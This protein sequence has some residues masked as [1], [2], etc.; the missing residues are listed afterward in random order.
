[1][2]NTM[3]LPRHIANTIANKYQHVTNM[4]LTKHGG[5][6]TNK[7]VKCTGDACEHRTHYLCLIYMST[8]GS[9]CT[10]DLLDAKNALESYPA[11]AGQHVVRRW[12]ATGEYPSVPNGA[13]PDIDGA[14]EGY[15]VVQDSAP[16]DKMVCWK[17][18]PRCWTSRRR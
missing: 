4:S 8:A 9:D 15:P 1:M 11:V 17:A 18:G 5:E 10:D 13:L 16:P 12:R 2:P 3:N 6:Q 7:H 14:L